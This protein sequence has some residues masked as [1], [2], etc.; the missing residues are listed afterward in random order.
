MST[1]QY[2]KKAIKGIQKL[3]ANIAD[4]FRTAFQEIADNRGNWDVKKL[5]GREG[6]RLRIGGYRGIYK[7]EGEQVMVIVFDVSPR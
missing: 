5:T 6:Y 7:I 4:Q 2:T 1:V 3:P